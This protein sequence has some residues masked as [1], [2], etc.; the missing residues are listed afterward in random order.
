MKMKKIKFIDLFC[1]IGGFHYAIDDAV[2]KL[3]RNSE[4]VFSS[5]IDIQSRESY[6]LNFGI[7]PQGD[8]TKINEKEIPNHDILLGGFPCQAFSIIGD[9]KGFED[10]RGTLFFDIARILKEKKPAGFVLENVKQLR[11]HNGGKTLQIILDTLKE[12]GYDVQYKVLNALDFGLP[13]KRERIFLVG[14]RKKLTFNWEFDIQKKIT[15]SDLIEKD[16]KKFYYA[17]TD[18]KDKRREMV[19]HHQINHDRPTIWH[20]NK[21][22]N[23]SAYE[24]SCALRAGAS[25]N[26]LLVNGERRLTE[27]EMLR[28]QGFPDSFKFNHSYTTMRRFAGNSLPIPMANAVIYRLLELNLKSH[29]NDSTTNKNRNKD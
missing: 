29:G 6:K 23:I 13:Q 7:E 14:W 2:K 27:R 26:Y 9:R 20:E 19:K 16:V 21:S 15:L 25:Y 22:G 8:I 28:L 24:Y 12:L 1:G 17:S 11:G 4:C 5:D 3:G 18:I 10:T